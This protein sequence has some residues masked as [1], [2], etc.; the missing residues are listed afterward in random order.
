MEES[1]NKRYTPAQK[2]AVDKYRHKIDRIM[3]TIPVGRKKVYRDAAE[4]SGKS[5]NKYI[6]DCVESDIESKNKP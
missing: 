4:A 6:V 2:R 1:K 5:L 3:L